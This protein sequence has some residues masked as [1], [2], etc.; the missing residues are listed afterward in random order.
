MHP[1]HLVVAVAAALAGLLL[2]GPALSDAPVAGSIVASD[3]AWSSGTGGAPDVAVGVGGAVGFSYPTGSSQHNVV[4]TGAQPSECQTITG[5]ASGSQAP[6]PT[7][8]SG[9]GWSGICRFDSAGTYPFVCGLHPGMTGSVTVAG[10]T[11][12]PPPPPP[13]PPPGTPPPPPPSS[14]SSTA[15]AGSVPRVTAIQHGF[16]VRGSVVVRTARS[17]LQTR[18]HAAR[19]AV[20]GGH[21]AGSVAIGSQ[22]RRSVARGRTSFAVKLGAAARRAL[23]RHGRLAVSVTIAVTPPTGTTYTVTRKVS[24]RVAAAKR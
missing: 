4:F 13:P 18:A 5:P 24:M 15:A 14:A 12:G 9:P 11:A 7:S 19:A 23:H 20:S 6:L 3:F 21:R 22:L 16:T 10:T 1:R 8:P 2:A 17:R